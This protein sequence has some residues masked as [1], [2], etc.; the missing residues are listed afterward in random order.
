[1]AQTF[2]S[3]AKG[4]GHVLLDE[5]GLKVTAFRVSHAPIEPAVGYR[6]DYKGRSVVLSGD[7]AKS[8][9]LEQFARGVD[10][11]VHEAL[12]PQLVAV[13]TR[14]TEK[15]GRKNLAKITRDI[16]DYHTSPIEVAEVARDAGVGHL[17][18]NHIV[19]P[20]LLPPMEDIF[21]EG[22]RDVYDGPVTLGRDGTSVRLAAGTDSI[23][24]VELL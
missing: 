4:A 10:L 14:G 24:V 20:L 5:D 18:Y 3:P 6:F 23:E 8:A 2:A 16:V 13:I 1:M 22:V 21:L 15:A 12:A 19:P 7:T 11:L 9:N 17:L